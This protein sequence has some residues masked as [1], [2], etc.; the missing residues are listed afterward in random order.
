MIPHT[1]FWWFRTQILKCLMIP[2]MN[3]AYTHNDFQF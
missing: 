2:H 1:N 3:I